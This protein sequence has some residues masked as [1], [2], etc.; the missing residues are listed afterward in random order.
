VEW[1]YHCAKGYQL[2]GQDQLVTGSKISDKLRQ[3]LVRYYRPDGE[4]DERTLDS[5]SR[6][7]NELGR[8]DELV[9]LIGKQARDDMIRAVR[10]IVPLPE[11]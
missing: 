8:D 6:L 7:I 5:A 10:D 3:L 2:R 9:T 11:S 1:L 4:L